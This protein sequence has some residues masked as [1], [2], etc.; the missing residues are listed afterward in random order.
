[1]SKKS[2]R[3]RYK[4][5]AAILKEPL[6]HYWEK[7]VRFSLRNC[8]VDKSFCISKLTSDYL[9]RLYKTLHQ[10]ENLTFKS[11]DGLPREKGLTS[12]KRDT[13]SY[14][15]LKTKYPAYDTFG[16]FRVDGVPTAFRV[17]CAKSNDLICILLLDSKGAV[18]KH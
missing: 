5:P 4:E 7:P 2:I 8:T 12:E 14:V 3:I 16:H 17:F 13:P 1:M 18:H 9:V 6:S 10:F 15:M 11:F